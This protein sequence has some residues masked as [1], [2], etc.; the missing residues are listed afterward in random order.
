ML[1]H[2]TLPMAGNGDDN[3]RASEYND[4]DIVRDIKK[5]DENDMGYG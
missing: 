3:E 2:S 4:S 1:S 5:A